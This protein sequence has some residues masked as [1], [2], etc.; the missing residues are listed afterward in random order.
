M[1]IILLSHPIPSQCQKYCFIFLFLRFF[2]LFFFNWTSYLLS[3]LDRRPRAIHEDIT[4]PVDEIFSK[5]VIYARREEGVCVHRT[6][7]RTKENGG[8]NPRWPKVVRR[9]VPLF[10]LSPLAPGPHTLP[11]Q[12]HRCLT[13]SSCHVASLWFRCNSAALAGMSV[14]KQP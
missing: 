4:I 7:D 6:Q 1:K 14:H 8:S 5:I 13:S 11:Q 9:P 12:S 3:H 10:W 2:P